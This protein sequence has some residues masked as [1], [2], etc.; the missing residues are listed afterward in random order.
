M[1]IGETRREDSVRVKDKIL[2]RH[3]TSV[4]EEDN[5]NPNKE[6]RDSDTIVLGFNSS[7]GTAF[8][9]DVGNE[10]TSD[11]GTFS[12]IEDEHSPEEGIDLRS[13]DTVWSSE[14]LD[15]VEELEER[16]NQMQDSNQSTMTTEIN[17]L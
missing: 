12:D 5:P 8:F 2:T 14:S 17:N 9:R 10:Q 13:F 1:D 15:F 3:N 11:R 16:C 7:I 6:P 4:K